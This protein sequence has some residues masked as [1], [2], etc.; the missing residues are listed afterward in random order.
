MRVSELSLSLTG[1]QHGQRQAAAPRLLAG[2][3]LSLEPGARS[4]AVAVSRSDNGSGSEAGSAALDRPSAQARRTVG[5][6]GDS[7]ASHWTTQ[8]CPCPE[9]SIIS[10]P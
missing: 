2:W 1:A 5:I 3:R 10:C 4:E 9:H 8:T 6:T 7:N